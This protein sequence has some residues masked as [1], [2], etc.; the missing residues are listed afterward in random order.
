MSVYA[1]TT[2][3][4]ALKLIVENIQL[5]NTIGFYLKMLVYGN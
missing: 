2:I 4:S 3:M 1:T 5:L